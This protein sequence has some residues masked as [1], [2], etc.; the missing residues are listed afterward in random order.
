MSNN[1]TFRILRGLEGLAEL[2]S[3]WLRL[4]GLD[5]RTRYYQ[6]YEWYACIAESLLEYDLLFVAAEA[7]DSLVGVFPLHI[8]KRVRFGFSLNYLQL[9]THSHARLGDFLVDPA[10]YDSGL[11]SRLIRFLRNTRE[12]RWDFIQ[13]DDTPLGS[14][15]DRLAME[16]SILFGSSEVSGS[17]SEIACSGGEGESLSHLSSRF[18]R[19]VLRLERRACRLGEV[20]FEVFQNEEN[21]EEGLALFLDIEHDGWKGEAGSSIASDAALRKFYSSLVKHFGASNNCRINVL[22]VGLEAVAAHF[23]IIVDETFFMLKIGY[24]EAFS[25]LGPGNILLA[26]VLRHFSNDP[27]VNTV[28]FV[29]SPAWAEKWKSQSLPVCTH[30]IFRTSFRGLSAFAVF[31]VMAWLKGLSAKLDRKG[32]DQE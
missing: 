27:L 16:D 8:G 24:R 5:N 4:Q 12:L 21:L 26:H 22:R 18:K 9:P 30:T 32:R 10:L 17:I 20:S 31:N 1:V 13:L 19:N 28:N 23:G 14:C 29:T 7:D 6:T 11:Y 2:K 25:K 15:A 3:G